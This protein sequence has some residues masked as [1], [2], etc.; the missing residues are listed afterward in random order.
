ME[1]KRQTYTTKLSEYKERRKAWEQAIDTAKRHITLARAFQD[2]GVK[3]IKMIQ[4]MKP[5]AKIDADALTKNFQACLASI[6]KGTKIERE[7]NRELME[8]YTFEPKEK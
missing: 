4:E 6:E 7:A 8:L 5:G 1:T 2:S 3:I